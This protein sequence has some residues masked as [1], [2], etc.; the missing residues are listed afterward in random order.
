MKLLRNT[1]LL[2]LGLAPTIACSDGART[3]DTVLQRIERVENG[4][5]PAVV[6]RGEELPRHSIREVMQRYRVPGVGIAVINNGRLEWAKGYG[7]KQVGGMSVDTTT[8]FLAGHISQGIA[9][10]AALRL[11]EAGAIDL[12][13]S[14]NDYLS[15]WQI[16]DNEFTTSEPVTL[17]RIM[18]HT[19]GLS[20]PSLLG[21]STEDVLPTLE[22][23]LDGIPPA[24]N[25]PIR[26]LDAPGSR[27]RYSLGGYVVL[28]Q[29][30]QDIAGS[31]YADYARTTVLSP[32]G[33][34]RSFHTQ[35]LTEA[36]AANAASGYEPSNEQVAG[37]WRLY[38]ELAALGL[39][40]T[41]SD[42]ARLALELQRSFSGQ[43]NTVISQGSAEQMLA[44]QFENRGLGY[45]VGGEGDW[46]FFR[47]EGHGNNYIS[48]LYAYVSRGRGAVVM[49]NSSHGE[50][51]KAHVLR[52]IA[53]EYGW[54]D[55]VPEEI[56]VVP[57]SDEVLGALEGRYRFRGRDRVLVVDRGRIFQQSSGDR[58]EELLAMSDDQLVSVSFGY[59][60]D[61]DRDAAGYITGLT[62]VLQSTRLFTYERVD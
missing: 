59:R 44:Q 29:L 46:R 43:S 51:V 18:S 39:W 19:S 48:E 26:V 61:I 47:L 42:L 20:V 15:S 21:Y 62:L 56:D 10:I 25:P 35:P 28:Q 55:Y 22:Q 34:E 27:Q 23:I 7:V 58:E 16:P 37:R 53:A 60:Y 1:L 54:P 12:D 11:V 36:L 33:M 4:L 17:R 8:L 24:A 41:P 5:L 57:L 49:T 14:V 9:A 31:S 40:T 52:A 45:E 3:S 2:S 38:P 30:L 32:L 6:V 13:Q 50:G